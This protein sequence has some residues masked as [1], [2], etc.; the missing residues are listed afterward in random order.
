MARNVQ[1]FREDLMIPGIVDPVTG[2][3][4]SSADITTIAM[5]GGGAE[6]T[7]P[8]DTPATGAVLLDSAA[9]YRKLLITMTALAINVPAA[10]DIGATAL[11]QM[12]DKFVTIVSI[13]SNFTV[14]R[15]G[16]NIAAAT[17]VSIAIGSGP[18]ASFP[19]STGARDL[20][21]TISLTDAVLTD[22]VD[23]NVPDSAQGS[24]LTTTYP[25]A[26]GRDA[27]IYLNAGAS[28]TGSDDDLLVTGTI[29]IFYLDAGNG[30]T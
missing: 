8:A 30:A 16:T 23:V 26:L 18:N 15:D 7:D 13:N 1:K 4:A 12:G 3:Y 14:T 25:I 10:T 24:P 21:Q 11:C 28:N 5:T 20:M 29:E 6:P 17:A 2:Q 27:T 19:M 9:P 22:T